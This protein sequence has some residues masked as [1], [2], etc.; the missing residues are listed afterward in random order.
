MKKSIRF[1]ALALAVLSVMLVFASCGKKLSG[2]YT[3][4]ADL[5]GLAG[6]SVTYKFS[7]K[8]VTITSTA[9]ILGQE[10]TETKTAK[11]AI[12]EKDDGT[13][14]ITFTYDDGKSDTQIFKE[15]KENKTITIGI[16]TLTKQ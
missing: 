6:A 13:M 8:K 3:G 9:S 2:T 16:V 12:T 4:K 11:Y 7:G 5:F 10:K 15:N 14:S 1:I